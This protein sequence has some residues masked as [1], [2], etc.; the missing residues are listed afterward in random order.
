MHVERI[1]IIIIERFLGKICAGH[2]KLG[3]FGV[4]LDFKYLDIQ[5]SLT[6]R[7][8]RSIAT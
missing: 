4:A 3:L 7:S 5:C 1:H 8:T 6:V 2:I